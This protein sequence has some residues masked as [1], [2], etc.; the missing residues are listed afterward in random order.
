MTGMSSA[1]NNLPI[2][3]YKMIQF[4]PNERSEEETNHQRIRLLLLLSMREEEVVLSVGFVVRTSSNKY[5]VHLDL[6]FS[7]IKEAK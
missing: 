3:G 2:F 5:V 6:D 7:A 4:R 1:G